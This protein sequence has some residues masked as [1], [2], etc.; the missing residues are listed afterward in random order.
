MFNKQLWQL[1]WLIEFI[2]FM[3]KLNYPVLILLM[4]TAGLAFYYKI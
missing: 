3:Q 2:Y 4:Q 1:V